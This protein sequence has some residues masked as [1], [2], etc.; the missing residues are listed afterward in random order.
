[1]PAERIGCFIRML[2][3]NGAKIRKHGCPVGTLCTE[4]AKLDNPALPYA[5]QLF[6]LFRQWL[7]SQFRALGHGKVAADRLAMHVLA[8]SQ[9]IATLAH[10]FDDAAFIQQEVEQLHAWLKALAPVPRSRTRKGD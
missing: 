9:G 7:A 4:L 1:L 2:V 10:A 3:M 8:R 6:D 5:S